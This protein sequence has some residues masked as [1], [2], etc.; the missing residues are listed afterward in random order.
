LA[1]C[2]LSPRDRKKSIAELA[3]EVTE[4]LLTGLTIQC[5]DA[6]VISANTNAEMGAEFNSF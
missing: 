5:C 6:A 3:I 1:F 2:A 4:S